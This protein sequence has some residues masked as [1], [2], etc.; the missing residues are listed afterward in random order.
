MTL[1]AKPPR[2]KRCRACR[3][4][5]AP[6]KSLQIAC[7]PKCALD[8]VAKKREAERK[9]IQQRERKELR[10]RKEKLKSRADH[11]REAQSVINR[12]VRLRDAHLGCVSCDKAPEWQGQW[13]AS[14]FR[15]V[16]AAPHL[17]FNLL[18]IHKACSVCN[19]HLSGNLMNY[20][21][22]LVL[23]IGE[24]RVE[25]LESN[26]ARAGFDIEYLKRLKRVFAK[27]CRRLEVRLQCSA[28]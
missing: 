28:A 24:E 22:A 6:A 9:S 5:F 3:E 1:T 10:V 20:R 16:G 17:R 18:N 4:T 26:H 11:L 12:Y 25:W 27:K 19:N 23:R 7:S 14:H 8:L 21:P 13:H 15:S 2:P